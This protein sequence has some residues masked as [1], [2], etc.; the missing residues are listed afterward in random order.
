MKT[1][2][3]S[4]AAGLDLGPPT[5]Q[6]K[7]GSALY[8]LLWLMLAAGALIYLSALIL[9]PNQ[10]MA[11]FGSPKSV[12]TESNEM[13]EADPSST[14]ALESEIAALKDQLVQ[15]RGEVRTVIA[16]NQSLTERLDTIEN[17]SIQVQTGEAS[18][19]SVSQKKKTQAEPEESGITGVVIGS[20]GAGSDD[21]VESEPAV[22]TKAD[23]K[24]KAEE[25]LAEAGAET[26]DQL[27]DASVEPA[28]KAEKR[29]FGLELAVSTS[30]EALQ[31]NWDL[32]NE[33]HG[34]VLKGLSARAQANPNDPS[35]YRLVTGPFTSAQ[36]AQS[37]CAKLK[38][39]NVTCQ[40]TGFGGDNL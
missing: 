25:S 30:P 27:A 12:A 32:L 11:V 24:K 8:L 7:R 22:P 39:Q 35:S 9:A 17:A 15:V 19:V 26:G 36:Q 3:L 31:L 33:R 13:A 20:D 6:R 16:T 34:E 37:V 21:L 40:V 14:A 1:N 5:P 4:N 23:K 2:I 18:A 29:K 28:P 10:L 38:K